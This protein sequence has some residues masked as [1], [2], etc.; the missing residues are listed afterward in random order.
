MVVTAFRDVGY[1]YDTTLW[2]THVTLD[3]FK[4]GVLDTLGNHFGRALV[5]SFFIGVVT[6]SSR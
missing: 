5:N 6:T 1:T 3:N 2:P 4:A